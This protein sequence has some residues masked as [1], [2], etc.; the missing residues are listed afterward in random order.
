MTK[1]INLA[2]QGGGSHG[3]F[4]WGVLDALLADERITLEG[5][6]GTS[7]GA[8]NAVVLADGLMRGGRDGA[9][10]HLRKFW[11]ALSRAACASP[12]RRSP[13]DILTGNWSLDYSPA[14]LALDATSRMLLPYQTNPLN[15]NP[16]RDLLID[17]VDFDRVRRCDAIRLYISATNVHTGKVKVFHGAHMT[18]DM[19]MASACLPMLFQAVVID[20]QA[21]WDGGYMGNPALFPFF[22]HSRSDDIMVVQINPVERPEIPDT[23]QEIINRMN[24]I[25]FNS[26]LLREMRAIEFISRLI[27]KGRLTGDKYR[28]VHLHVIG[29]ETVLNPLGASSKMNAEPAFLNMLHD[30]GMRTAQQWLDDN[31]DKIGTESTVD[32]SAMF[33]TPDEESP[34]L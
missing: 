34:P 31:Y 20:G 22:R 3:A 21:Y 13:L 17:V 23:S 7:A 15:I 14:Y 32:L 4:T 26:S 18:P 33:R 12:L 28:R 16:L 29:N 10:R 27:D 19:V 24:E 11:M 1:L 5:V 2:L 9:R 30:A 25:T 6:S 8:M